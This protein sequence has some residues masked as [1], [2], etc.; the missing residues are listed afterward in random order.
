[1]ACTDAVSKAI[2]NDCN[3]NPVAGLKTTAYIGNRAD[4]TFTFDATT[5]N[6]ITAMA[7]AST[8]QFYKVQMVKKEGNAGFDLVTSDI[9]PDTFAQFF[10]IMPYEDDAASIANLDSMSDV[11]L[12]IERKGAED[13]GS[14]T[15]LGVK[16]GMHR[17]SATQRVNDNLGMATY[18]FGSLDGQGENY[19]RYKFWDTDYATTAAAVAA[20]ETPG[21]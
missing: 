5:P 20:L 12:V 2:T 19:S 4:V 17:L 15:V 21:A 13:E 3:S 7:N 1:M 10:S 18:E 14:F 6:L 8:K 9:A 16:N 11:V